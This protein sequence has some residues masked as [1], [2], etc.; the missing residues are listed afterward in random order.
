MN[1]KLSPAEA[2]PVKAFKVG[3]RV[4]IAKAKGKHRHCLAVGDEAV[5]VLVDGDALSVK[6]G[7]AT[8]WV[9]KSEVVAIGS[10]LPVLDT[11]YTMRLPAAVK[12]KAQRIGAAAVIAAIEAAPE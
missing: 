9:H 3:Q 7:G 8:Q 11:R 12:A 6:V 4:V 10:P 2:P 1:K 5:V